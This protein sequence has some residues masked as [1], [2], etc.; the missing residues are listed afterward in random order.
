MA[1]E[2]GNRELMR[3]FES[4]PQTMKK[5]D[6]KGLL[7]PLMESCLSQK[8]DLSGMPDGFEKN[9]LEFELRRETA[10]A[11]LLVAKLKKNQRRLN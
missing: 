3:F 4:V 2:A 1:G 8:P 6:E 7:L 5:L 11:S 9:L 10:A